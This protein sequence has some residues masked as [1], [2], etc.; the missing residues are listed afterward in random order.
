MTRAAH[1]A[2]GNMLRGRLAGPS[3]LP[4]FFGILLVGSALG[5][6][7]GAK[8]TDKTL[9]TPDGKPVRKV[10][11]DA[12]SVAMANAATT[13]LNQ[14]TCLTI[15]SNPT[16]ADAVLEVGI[17]L[18]SVAGDDADGPDIFGSKPHA[19]TL[20]NAHSS[21][22]KRTA[23]ATCSDGKGGSGAC[24]TSYS[25]QGGELPE[26]PAADW[27]EGLGPSYTVSLASPGNSSQDLWDPDGH[28]KHA[29][30]SDQLR[31]AAGC[32]VCPGERFNPRR[33]KMTYR[34]WM[35][36]KCPDVLPATT[37]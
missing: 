7:F 5:M 28:I 1:N 27:T 4:I 9:A 29:S 33:D 25:A 19:Q 26:Q 8:K 22:P 2:R 18:P 30:W 15:V 32:P 14:D 20:G 31:Q 10:Y 36:A 3:M 35:D 13:Q 21:G 34:Q 23:S 24:T 11:V 12:D 17:A 37:K 16:Q 6:A